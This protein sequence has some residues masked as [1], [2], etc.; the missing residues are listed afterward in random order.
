MADTLTSGFIVS[1]VFSRFSVTFSHA[2]PPPPGGGGFVH[3]F[4]KEAPVADHD[5]SLDITD[6]E[7]VRLVM[8]LDKEDPADV[9]PT[10]NTTNK[11][12]K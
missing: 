6:D 11:G 10:H 7:H 3:P 9:Q 4:F 2:L 8:R 12:G 5:M 1:H